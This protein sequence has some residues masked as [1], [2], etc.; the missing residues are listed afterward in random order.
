MTT[1]TEDTVELNYYAAGLVARLGDLAQTRAQI[2]EEEN[3]LKETLRRCL[4]VGTR[5][6]I[7]GQLA[8]TLVA[9][10]RFDADAGAGLLDPALRDRCTLV[11]FDPRKVRQYLAPALVEAC[12][13]AV[14]EAKVVLAP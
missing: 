7:N 6:T 13:V 5:G 4:A 12:M 11:G 9:N 8:V 1:T 2:V 14:G 10:R 3:E